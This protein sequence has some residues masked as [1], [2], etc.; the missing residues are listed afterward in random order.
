MNVGLGSLKAGGQQM[1]FKEGNGLF[2]MIFCWQRG[3]REKKWQ[4]KDCLNDYSNK[5]G[6][7][8]L[9]LKLLEFGIPGWRSDL[10]PAFGPGRDPG[11]PGSNPTLGSRCM[12]PAS[13]SACVSASLSLCV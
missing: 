3:K 13:P 10:A 5:N 1:L 2:Q 6:Q 9:A 11:D 8:I 12:E 4:Q 7:G